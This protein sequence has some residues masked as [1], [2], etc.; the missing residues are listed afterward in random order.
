MSALT[1]REH[2]EALAKAVCAATPNLDRTSLYLAAESSDFIRFNRAAVRQ[3][4]HVLQANA[5]L[6]VVRGA[7]RASITVGLSGDPQE[8][9]RL[10]LAERAR[11]A[12]DLEFVPDDPWL[13][14]PEV[15]SHSSRESSGQLPEVAAAIDAVRSRGNGHDLVGFLASGPQVRAYADSLGSRHW[16][17]VESFNFDWCLYHAADKAVKSSY[18]GTHWS[19]G[20]LD[21]RLQS[22]AQ[23][24]QL[25]QRAPHTLAPGAYR[26]AFSPSAVASLLGTLSW[27]GF[28]L[29]DRRTGVST[30]MQLAHGDARLSTQFDLREATARST[31]PSFTPDGFMRPDEVVLV[32]NG[33]AADTLNSPRSAREY[34]LAAN[35]ALAGEQPEALELAPGSIAHDKLLAT[36]GTGL[37]VSN[38]W[39]LNYS[40]RQACRMTGMTRFACFWVENGE[41]R[42]PVNVMRF[43]DSF[44]RMFGPGLVGLTDR[45]EPVPNAD[46]WGSRQL[47]GTTVPAAIVSDWLLTL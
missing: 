9:A 36:L 21:T 28:G 34:G 18:A 12:A 6:A 47:G 3:A 20:E 23:R 19:D 33:Q 13:L 2:F 42:A 22:A 15:Q 10:L 30:L 1:Q 25:L 31:S 4:T 5:T 27:G 40:D 11:L 38:L 46:T 29:K 41:L 16:H 35:G 39:Y 17:R 26:T 7:R 14:L 8:D 43:D 32:R 44:L 24:V 37:Y 45:A